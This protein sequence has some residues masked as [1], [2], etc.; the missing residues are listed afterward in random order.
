MTAGGPL[1]AH[2][3]GPLLAPLPILANEGP[4]NW[5]VAGTSCEKGSLPSSST[6][7]LS[8]FPA[9]EVYSSFKLGSWFLEI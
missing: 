4:A 3:G 1:A 8:D 9:Q 6:A 5:W 7:L 2:P